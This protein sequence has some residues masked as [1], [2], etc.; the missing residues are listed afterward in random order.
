MDPGRDL[1][2]R[3]LR[4]L[5]AG[6]TWRAAW[7]DAHLADD[8]DARARR[9]ALELAGGVTRLRAR[10][11]AVIASHARRP[12]A[13]LDPAV[14]VALRMGV[15]QLFETDGVAAHAAVHTSVELAK[16]HAPRA[17]P[18]ANAVLRAAQRAGPPAP[19]RTRDDAAWAAY[20]SH[21]EWL[22]AR[23]RRR[24]GDASAA[25]LC[26]YANRRPQLCLRARQGRITRDALRERLPESEPGRFSPVA[27]RLVAPGYRSARDCVEAGLASVQDESAMLVVPALTLTA[28]EDVLDVSAAPGGKTC[29]AAEV[30]GDRG[31][32]RAFDRTRAR[33]ERIRDNARRLGLECIVAAAGDARRLVTE[34]ADAVLVDAPCSG[35]GVL[36]RKPDLRWRQQPADLE[37]LGALQLEMLV[38][39]A[40]HVR[41]GGRLVYSLCAFEPE[42][43]TAVVA[44]F[45]AACPQFRPDDD[46]L[47]LRRGPGISYCL[48]HEHGIDGG[49]VARWR[50]Q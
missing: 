40:G 30:M 46:G 38:A 24:F 15:Y 5:E 3:I 34:P 47:V 13:G 4:R 20:W 45:A 26:A 21:P 14:H 23:W 43:T 22:V 39:A 36:G 42:E 8:G 18:F 11:D 9:F 32:V 50:R 10:L 27:V 16:Q 35:L 2:F 12:V 17:A 48:P 19:P 25:A 31:R 44:A 41:P 28:G 33:V 29:H 1:A 6:T 37:R 49:F 7:R